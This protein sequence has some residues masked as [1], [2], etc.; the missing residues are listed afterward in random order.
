MEENFQVQDWKKMKNSQYYVVLWWWLWHLSGEW[1]PCSVYNNNNE[2][3]SVCE[4]AKKNVKK[5]SVE[6]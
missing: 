4:A 2:R 1:L 5:F 3:A 6:K